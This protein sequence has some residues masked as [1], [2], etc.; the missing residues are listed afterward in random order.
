ML[1]E[2]T[3]AF[4]IDSEGPPSKQRYRQVGAGTVEHRRGK[5]RERDLTYPAYDLA[6]IKMFE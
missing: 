5:R 3:M 2:I 1:T 6:R 4:H